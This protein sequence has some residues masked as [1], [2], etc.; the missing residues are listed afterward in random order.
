VQSNISDI[1][2]VQTLLT[3]PLQNRIFKINKPA[4]RRRYEV[5]LKDGAP[6]ITVDVS[7]FTPGVPELTFKE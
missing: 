6:L 1:F 2:S 3:M 7:D 4:L 5:S